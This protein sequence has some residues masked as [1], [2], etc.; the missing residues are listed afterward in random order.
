MATKKQLYKKILLLEYF[1][2]AWN[3]IEGVVSISI[4]LVSGSISL[5][6]F[7]LESNIE[8]FSS[9]VTVW[10]LKGEGNGRRKPALKMISSALIVVAIYISFDAIK[11]FFDGHRPT[12]T[13]TGIVAMSLI[14]ITMLMVGTLKKRLGHEMK[15]PVIVAESN[16]TLLD[17]ALSASILCGLILNA[18][19]GWWWID[20]LLAL[21]IAGNAFW[22]G[23]KGISANKFLTRTI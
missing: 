10:Q 22:Q 20:Q 15:D 12:P 9:V 13:I 11:S 3:L 21:V 18:L 8:V 17:S 5:V 1:T 14:T 4:G 19:M 16:F 6:A 2:I 23:A 7:G